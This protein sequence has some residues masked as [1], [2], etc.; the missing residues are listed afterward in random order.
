M[1]ELVRIAHELAVD[2]EAVEL[3]VAESELD[4]PRIVY[5]RSV[6]NYAL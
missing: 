4:F 6:V 2:K 5:Y 3:R 1:L